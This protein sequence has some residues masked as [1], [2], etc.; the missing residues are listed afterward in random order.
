MSYILSQIF[1][2]ISSAAAILSL[3][4]KNIKHVLICQLLCNSTGAV[5][6]ILTGGLSGCGIYVIAILQSL[7]YSVYRIKEKKA[8]KILAA[9]FIASYIICSVLTYRVPYDL[10]S[11][12][13]AMTCAF[14]LIQENSSVYRIF[15]LMNGLIWLVYDFILGAYTMMF[16]HIA[17]VVSATIGII[18]FDIKKKK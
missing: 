17:T 16:S 10:L 3:Q 5:S 7:I 15:I 2:I 18:R 13:A 1:G 11:A 9:V 6:Y 14:A 8:P 12:A 4:T